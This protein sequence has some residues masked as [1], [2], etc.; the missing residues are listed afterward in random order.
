MS[1]IIKGDHV[2]VISGRDKGKQGQVTRLLGDKVVVEGVNLVKRHQKPNPM[3][4]VEG[5]VV[6][7]NMPI[8]ISNVAIY[9]KET[10]KAD[11]VG[12]KL[13]DDD[14]KVRRVRVFKS[15]GAELA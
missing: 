11:R 9:N 12:V 5:G 2:V 10:Q 14:G 3:R 13:I 7:K 1:K 8:H 15:N 4:N 6:I